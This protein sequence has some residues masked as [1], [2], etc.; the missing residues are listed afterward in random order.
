[1][2]Q[3]GS[4]IESLLSSDN[5]IR[6]TAEDSYESMNAVVKIPGLIQLIIETSVPLEVRGLATVLLRRLYV[7]NFDDFWPQL[8]QES[9]NQLKLQMINCVQQEKNGPIKKKVCE[10]VAELARNLLDDGVNKWP[11]FI[12]FLFECAHSSDADAR[13][14][15]LIIFSSVPGIFGNDQNQ[16]LDIRSQATKAT[17]S[18]LTAN[19]TDNNLLNHFKELLPYMLQCIAESI[20]KLEDDSLLKCLID[21]SEYVPKY[22][23]FQ[24]DMYFN[25]II[26]VLSDDKIEE[27]WKH[28]ALE[29]VV[30][31]AEN[32]SAIMRKHSEIITTLVRLVLMMMV[33]LD[34]DDD[35]AIADEIEESDNESNPVV[36]ESALDR[37]CCGLGGKTM[38]PHIISIIPVML[39][40]AD[41]K[42]RHAG[43]MAISACGEGCHAQMTQVLPSIVEA[44]LPFFQDQHPR[45]RYAAC[46]AIGQ[47]STDFAPALQKKFADKIVPGLLRVMEENF[48]FPRVQAHSGAALVNF[49]EDCPKH[50]LTIFLEPIMNQLECVLT[51]KFNELVEKGNKLVLEQVV[52]TLASVADTAQEK[53]EVYYPKFMP[54]LKYIF[55][56]ATSQELRNLRGKTIECISLIGLA[57][58]K[59]KFMQ[60]CSEMMELLLKTHVDWQDLPDDDP[61]I[62]YLISAWARICKIMGRDFEPYLPLVMEPVLKAA[63]FK[64]EVA[65]LDS[66]DMKVLENDN[67][68]Q[69]VTL[70]DQQSFGIRTAGLEEKATACQMLVCYARELKGGFVE[71][72]EQ[73][74]K[75][76]VSHLKFYFHEGVRVAAAECLPPLLECA[77]IKGPEYLRNI[78]QYICPEL[79]KAIESDPELSVKAEH[80]SSL[81]QCIELMGVNCLTD[82][83]MQKLSV[84]LNDILE[85]HF[86][87]HEEKLKEKQ[88]DE[89]Y[90]EENESEEEND[91]NLVLSKVSD[92]IHSLFGTYKELYLPN[93]QQLLPQFVRLISP[94][95]PWS[96]RQWGLCI[97]DDL[98]EFAGP[99]SQMFIQYFLESMVKS[100]TDQRPEVR[101]AAAYGVGVMAKFG[102]PAFAGTCSE[103]LP[104][105]TRVI[106]EATSRSPEN[107]CATENAISAV[108]KICRYNSSQISNMNEVLSLWLSWLPIWEDEE[109]AM[110]VYDYLC[111]LIELN[112]PVVLGANNCNLPNLLKIFVQSFHLNA[113]SIRSETGLRII[114]IIR[115]LKGNDQ[116]FHACLSE[117]T[118]DQQN[119]LML[120]LS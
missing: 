43:L 44:I 45:V 77:Q 84:I 73:V 110:Q 16:Y 62:S 58:G 109:E 7:S 28:L 39:Q 100:I 13:E 4:L 3:F 63:S 82:E 33:D 76:M 55:Q 60:D 83:L 86:K 12:K 91:Y 31:F 48:L 68:W 21:I 24:L 2:A 9:Q 46:N 72:T 32:A 81:S 104:L 8:P 25:L 6:S 22:F 14:C 29:S 112:N 71:Y 74:V 47:M 93:F 19:E 99:S 119:T 97:F 35:W 113:V 115:Q 37:L 17:A 111:E 85:T 79:L 117:L 103:V 120:A 107:V 70:E 87:R 65:L 57:V 50:I 52:T 67:E 105:L 95:R 51:T 40:N 102:G 34:D 18:F 80:M 42:Q 101:Q 114:N 66:D 56:N 26:K 96:D 94:D 1:M 64:P 10:G 53:F 89:D 92:I 90:D 75:I 23:K 36:G 30:L 11:E 108:A 41:W 98:L 88:T 61:Q 69:F 106:Q 27:N 118:P 15:A 20:E 54:C 38:L 78:W 5:T 49:S 59:E 116:I